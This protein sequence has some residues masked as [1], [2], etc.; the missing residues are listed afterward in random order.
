M[1]PPTGKPPKY[2]AL[3]VKGPLSFKMYCAGEGQA[4]GGHLIFE[5]MGVVRVIL[6]PE[7][8]WRAATKAKR[9]ASNKLKDAAGN[10]KIGFLLA[11]A[12]VLSRES[13]EEAERELAP[14]DTM[15]QATNQLLSAGKA[16]AMAADARLHALNQALTIDDTIPIEV[17]M[18]ERT[19]IDWFES[20]MAEWLAANNSDFVDAMN[21]FI[22]A[23]SRLRKGYPADVLQ[24]RRVL[25]E[26][27][28]LAG[29]PPTKSSVRQALGAEEAKKL[30]KAEKLANSMKPPIK[31]GSNIW[32]SEQLVKGEAASDLID[33]NTL[34]RLLERTG[35]T[36]LPNGKP[37]PKR[38]VKSGKGR[39]VE[40]FDLKI[41]KRKG[42]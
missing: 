25:A 26:Q 31:D 37:G 12:L 4:G 3:T 20:M 28:R 29:G 38:Q 24:F 34:T 18:N 36:W 10:W 42:R 5:G 32:I 2:Q 14:A 27:A 7:S 6:K 15:K 17:A 39:C 1:K 35:F 22:R 40:H 21:G 11:R 19:F 33:P 41:P 8:A 9:N 16:R 30:A 23:A 13:L